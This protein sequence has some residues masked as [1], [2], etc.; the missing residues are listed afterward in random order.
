ML[1]SFKSDECTFMYNSALMDTKSFD[2]VI[3]DCDGVLVDSEP[4]TNKVYV[5][6]LS[7]YGYDVNEDEFLR[8]F[9]GK[10]MTQRLEVISRKLG[11]TPPDDFVSIYHERLVEINVKELKPM[12]GVRSLI[13]SLTVPYCVA[14]NGSKQEIEHRLK[15]TQLTEL[16]VD[17]KIFSGTEMLYPKPAP[18]V[19]LAA[20]KS[21]NLP[22]ERCI[23][24][25]DSIPGITA[26]VRAGMKVYGYAAFTVPET[27]QQAGAIPFNNMA[28][29]Q[30]IL[31]NHE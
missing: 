5:Q 1:I 12:D 3:F 16:F 30:K 11:W 10:A 15:V 9:W 18:D 8:E 21:F 17:K 2:L 31:S 20:A 27:I 26:G 28:E 25:E 24:I 23:V 13:E 29:L 6:M 22:P 14:S 4:I 7:E 19:Y